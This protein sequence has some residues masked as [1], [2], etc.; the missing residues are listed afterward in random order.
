MTATPTTH[1]ATPRRHRARL[2]V[3]A[4]IAVLAF[5]ATTAAAD[6][7]PTTA[8]ERTATAHDRR[9]AEQK[10]KAMLDAWLR[11]WNGDFAQAPGI[12]SPGFRVHAALL[13][14][15]D[16]SSVRGVDGLVA[17]IGQT[18]AA[19]RDLRFTIEVPPLV[20]GRYAS[21]RWTATGTYAGGFPGAKAQPG[22]VVT[23][24]GTDTLRMRD[25]KFAEYWV[26]TDTLSLLTQLQAL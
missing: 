7:S 16:G 25:G 22:T 17:W 5:T 15:G 2:L 21:V 3:P 12:I 11:L 10:P 13:D 1:T 9:A 6:T 8:A 20:D 14:G 26:N 19:F 23:F 24:T 4:A 18:R